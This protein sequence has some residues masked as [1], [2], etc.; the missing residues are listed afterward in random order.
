MRRVRYAMS[1]GDEQFT[2]PTGSQIT[3]LRIIPG[4]AEAPPAL[5]GTWISINESAPHLIVCPL[6]IRAGDFGVVAGQLDACDWYPG[7]GQQMTITIGT[8]AAPRTGDPDNPNLG[9]PP[10][11]VFIIYQ[12]G[13]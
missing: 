7:E 6:E 10:Q 4:R 13:P 5:I 11:D 8:I 2:I 12:G 1:N 3:Y 9:A